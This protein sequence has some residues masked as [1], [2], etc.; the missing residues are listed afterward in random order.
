MPTKHGSYV[1]STT[2]QKAFA[3]LEYIGEHQPVTVPALQTDLGMTKGNVHRLLA[4]LDYLGYV[5]RSGDGYRLTFRM[6]ALGKTVPMTRDIVTAAGPVMHRIAEEERVNVYIS[7]ASNNR[8]VNIERVQARHE[9]QVAD[10]FAI[11][12]GF[13]C[14][15]SG[16]LYLSFRSPAER[17][18]IYEDITLD[19]I[20]D[21][22]I[23][24]R[25]ELEKRILEIQ[26]LGYSTEI[27]EHSPY[28]NGIAAPILDH[29]GAFVASLAVIGPA[30]ILT[31]EDLLRIAPRVVDDARS[32][33]AMIGHQYL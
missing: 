26:E 29:T 25:R 7:V 5:S 1:L 2:L 19:R 8:M 9:I 22:T 27:M 4:T 33:S 32:I 24:S 16:K 10:D 11:S 20:T 17:A 31:N 18:A 6:Y 15:A 13:H 21:H 12:Y 14:T 30:V 28:I 3:I 23:T